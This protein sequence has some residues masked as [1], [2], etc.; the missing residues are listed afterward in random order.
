MWRGGEIMYPHHCVE[1]EDDNADGVDR[2]QDSY[3]GSGGCSYDVTG[4]THWRPH[5]WHG[6]RLHTETHTHI[7]RSSARL[8][9]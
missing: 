5:S 6:T 2:H 1:E 9:S 4:T 3:A 7:N 8:F